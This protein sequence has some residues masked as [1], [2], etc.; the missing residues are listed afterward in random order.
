MNIYKTPKHIEVRNFAKPAAKKRTNK[1]NYS[2]FMIIWLILASIVA[3]L[4]S[5]IFG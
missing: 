1:I 2:A 3:G 4:F 5:W